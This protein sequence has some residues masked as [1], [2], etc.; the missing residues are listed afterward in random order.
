MPDGVIAFD[1]HFGP[2]PP[3]FLFGEGPRRAPQQQAQAQAQQPQPQPQSQP[4][5]QPQQSE[6]QATQDPS[7]PQRPQAPPLRVPGGL[8][9]PAGVHFGPRQGGDMGFSIL[10]L[11]RGFMGPPPAPGNQQQP[12]SPSNASQP[13]QPPAASE[14]P[15]LHP[16]TDSAPSTN[17]TEA[18]PAPAQSMPPS[19]DNNNSSTPPPPS[20]GNAGDNNERESDAAFFRFLANTLGN[21][22]AF[23][24]LLLAAGLMGGIGGS[25]PGFRHGSPEPRETVKKEWTPPP[26]PGP[27]LRQRVERREQEAGLR[28]SDVSCG[29]GPSDD[30][31]FVSPAQIATKQLSIHLAGDVSKPVCIHAFHSACLVS[32][33]RVASRG[34]EASIV[35]DDVEVSCPVC[36]GVGCVSKIDWDEGVQTLQ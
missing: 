36:R 11:L 23:L 27:T 3:G 1:I 4:Q 19:A 29:I 8:F 5:S 9:G 14:E 6:S 20:P 32:A 25:G 28:C 21:P 7:Q 35:G 26:A 24:R 13:A 31:P 22:S 33:E 34:A 17:P 16:T 10:D 15:Q 30:E 18:T 12:A 2:A